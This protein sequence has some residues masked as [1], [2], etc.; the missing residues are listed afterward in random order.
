[1][2]QEEVMKKVLKTLAQSGS[3]T[4]QDLADKIEGASFIQI[5]TA[6]K[7][8]LGSKI[9]AYDKATKQFSCLELKTEDANKTNEKAIDKVFDTPEQETGTEK[10]SKKESTLNGK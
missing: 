1:M 8:L 4:N 7:T 10:P 5:Q 6:T 2:K 9:V 3:S